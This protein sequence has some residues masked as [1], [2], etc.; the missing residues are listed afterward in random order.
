M[1]K[2]KK[3]LIIVIIAI[4]FITGIYLTNQYLTNNSKRITM[5][6]EAFCDDPYGGPFCGERGSYTVEST[7]GGYGNFLFGI[8]F[9][10]LSVIIG[11]KLYKANKR[12]L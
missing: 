12:K 6:Q 8:S 5:Q 9:I 2:N 4:L 1:N 11:Y 3:L 10:I 7:N